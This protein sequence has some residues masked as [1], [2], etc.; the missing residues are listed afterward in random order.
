MK[1]LAKGVAIE[2]QHLCGAHLITLG[3]G[4]GELEYRALNIR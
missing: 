4:Q 2:A 1:A 3:G